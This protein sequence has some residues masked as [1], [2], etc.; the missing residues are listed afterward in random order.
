MRA[1]PLASVETGSGLQ[2]GYQEMVL[3]HGND[4]VFMKYMIYRVL[5]VFAMNPL[6]KSKLVKVNKESILFL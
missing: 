5:I 6:E 4:Q 2:C 1:L 3:V